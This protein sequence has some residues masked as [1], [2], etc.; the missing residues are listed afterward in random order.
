MTLSAL[1]AAHPLPGISGDKHDRGVAVVVAGDPS[2]PGAAIL[3]ATAALRAGAGKV[4]VVT[5]AEIV[6]AIGT[7][8]PEALVLA[9][10]SDGRPSTAVRERVAMADAVLIGPG[11]LD[12]G[13]EDVAA[14][15][16]DLTPDTPLVLD[17]AAVGAAQRLAGHRLVLIPNV[18]EAAELA[19][20]EGSAGPER[21]GSE[22]AGAFGAAVAVRGEETVVTDGERC[23]SS[24]GHPGLGTAGSGDVLAGLVV[25]LC[26]RG[27]DPLGAVGW[28]VAI[29]AAAGELLA[30]R[31]RGYGYLARELLDVVPDAVAALLQ[32]GPR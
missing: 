2:C 23:W 22:L 3:S 8:V 25:G 1:L 26:A 4:Q 30:E 11:L 28:A 13:P 10:P 12:V 31:G 14:L 5:H 21:L 6:H 7:A 32:G 18:A 27:I 24:S 17:A 15:A 9:G 16:G 20:V 19:A 29:H